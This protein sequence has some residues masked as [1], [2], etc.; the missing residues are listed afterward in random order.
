M[1]ELLAEISQLEQ[2]LEE[3]D[4]IIEKLKGSLKNQLSDRFAKKS[5]KK[6]YIDIEKNIDKPDIKSKEES[7]TDSNKPDLQVVPKSKRKITPHARRIPDNLPI[8]EIVHELP[9][10]DRTCKICQKAYRETALT[11]ESTEIDIEI[12]ILRK[13]HVRKIYAKTCQCDE[14]QSMVVAPKPE[15]IIYKSL[16][17]TRLWV[18]LLV[19]KYHA[20]IPLYRQ[21]TNIWSQ[22]GMSFSPST[23]TGG[24]KK[25]GE[26]L[27]PLYNK[28]IE[29]SKTEEHWHADETRWKV[30]TENPG[31]KTNNWWM[32]VF[33]SVNVVVYIL[34]RTRSSSVPQKHLGNSS[35]IINVDRYS[36]YYIL[37]QTIKRALCWYHCRRDFIKA[38][39]AFPEI[40]SWALEWLRK[41]RELEKINDKRVFHLMDDEEFDKQH[42]LLLE[43]LAAMKKSSEEELLKNTLKDKQRSVLKSLLKNWESLTVFV[44]N[45]LVPMHNNKA[46]RFL[47][48]LAL[49]RKNF[50]GSRSE[51]SGD[52]AA[53][54]M[55]ICK[56]AEIHGLNPQAYIEFYFKRFAESNSGATIDIEPLLP[57]NI[58]DEVADSHNL[59]IAEAKTG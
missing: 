58:S 55:S 56:T 1:S 22:Y 3:K 23:I 53:M 43:Q 50:Y 49:S 19:L 8:I 28:L 54:C 33:A 35:G 51:W 5:E 20:N 13:K 59:R 41:I 10:E 25:L 14:T 37:A 45:P 11:E 46:E 31:K 2:Q 32:W 6:E 30:F 21:I 52:L 57:W 27:I 18:L 42:T 16:Y 4:A 34:D 12:K 40:K 24:F 36:A 44:S 9:P 26:S 15:N 17:S 38:A 47:R 29:V 7:E 48:G 39:I